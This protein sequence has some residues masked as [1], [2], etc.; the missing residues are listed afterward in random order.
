MPTDWGIEITDN[1]DIKSTDPL[2]MFVVCLPCSS[3][4]QTDIKVVNWYRFARGRWTDHVATAAHKTNCR[5]NKHMIEQQTDDT[6]KQPVLNQTSMF[7]HFAVKRKKTPSDDGIDNVRCPPALR[8]TPSC[9]GL[10]PLPSRATH[11]EQMHYFERYAIPPTN[12][13]LTYLLKHLPGD[14]EYP[15]IFAASCTNLGRQR[16]EKLSHGLRCDECE[17]MR[18][19][20]GLSLIHI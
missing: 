19:V 20:S 5:Q 3:I 17:K 8:I 6:Q 16:Y 1:K 2:G 4:Q 15:Q 9:E 18:R 14:S 7:L 10:L 12:N 11:C 13:N